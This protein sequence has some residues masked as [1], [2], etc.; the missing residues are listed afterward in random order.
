MLK[1]HPI[2]TKS[3]LRQ[4]VRDT[5][6]ETLAGLGFDTESPQA[7]QAD[8]VYLRRV[9]KGSEEMAGKVKGAV[10]TMLAT[11]AL[12]LLWEAFKRSVLGQ[13]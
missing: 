1:N 2:E 5:V 3:Q 4:I 8:M 9:R 13:K 11:A 6:R 12:Y 10:F 7:L